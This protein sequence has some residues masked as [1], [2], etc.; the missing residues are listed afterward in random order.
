MTGDERATIVAHISPSKA[1][2]KYSK[3]ENLKAISASAGARATSDSVPMMP[4]IAEN[5]RQMPK[6]QFGLPLARHGEGLVGIGRRCG[7]AGN[8]QQ[9]TGNVT[10]K[11]G[12]R[13][14]GNNGRNRCDR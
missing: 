9:T 8:A 11:N 10:G 13:R 14:G 5:H 3:V 4:P 2:Q 12:H 1:S 7:R 6:R